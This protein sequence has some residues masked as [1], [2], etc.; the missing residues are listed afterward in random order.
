VRTESPEVAL[1]LKSNRAFLK[2]WVLGAGAAYNLWPSVLDQPKDLSQVPPPLR[3]V[4]LPSGFERRMQFAVAYLESHHPP[5]R[6][7][8]PR[9]TFPSRQELE[10]FCEVYGGYAEALM[11]NVAFYHAP[12]HTIYCMGQMSKYMSSTQEGEWVA[13]IHL[14]AHEWFHSL[15]RSEDHYLPLEE[16]GAEVFAAKVG[17]E[18]TGID[19]PALRVAL[20]QPFAEGITLMGARLHPVGKPFSWMMASRQAGISVRHWMKTQF[21]RL[22]FSGVGLDNLMRYDGVKH[23]SQWLRTVQAELG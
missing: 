5:V 19:H 18:M 1:S 17:R 23:A 12:T 22:H 3:R 20:Y 13:G 11:E 10:A 15:R 4:L 21:T 14:L 16:G 2:R 8:R 9:V 7:V 6:G